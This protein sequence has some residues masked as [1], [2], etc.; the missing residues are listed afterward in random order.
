MGD[1]YCSICNVRRVERDG[2]VCPGCQD[3]YQQAVPVPQ[4]PQ[5]VQNSYAAAQSNDNGYID[6]PAVPI[7]RSNRRILGAA[8]QQT[9]HQQPSGLTAQQ[10]SIQQSAPLPVTN[11]VPVQPAASNAP[12]Q[13]TVAAGKKGPQAD[14]IV[15][16]IQESKDNTPVL[17]RWMRSFSYGVPFPLTDDMMEFQVFSGWNANGNNQNGYSADK[18]IVYGTINSGKPIQD[19]TVRVYGT[20]AKNNAIIASGIENTTDGTYAE[21]NPPPLP[22]AAVRMITFLVLGLLLF[23][24][25]GV[26]SGMGGSSSGSSAAGTSSGGSGFMTNLILTIMGGL[27]TLFCFGQVKQAFANREWGKV[28]EF[29]LFALFA[30]ALTLSFAKAI[31]GL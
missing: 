17:G 6:E 31:F 2:D 28:F 19:N 15:R 10:T 30:I 11:T 7:H 25:I 21:F 27:G 23:L 4:Q 14:G 18:V 5:T 20:R 16:N 13:N 24:I 9:N 1:F 29:F 3:P 22:A 26:V 12:A 8:P